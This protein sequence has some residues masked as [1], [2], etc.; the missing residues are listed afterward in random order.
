MLSSRDESDARRLWRRFEISGTEPQPVNLKAHGGSDNTSPRR[1]DI[2]PIELVT[3][4]RCCRNYQIHAYL[5]KFL[6]EQ[7]APIPNCSSCQ[8]PEPTQPHW[9]DS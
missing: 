8:M 6:R 2:E 5:A 3:C 4:R 1:A 9:S 7:R